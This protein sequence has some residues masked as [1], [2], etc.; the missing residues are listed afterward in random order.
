M[1]AV[2]SVG[3][4]GLFTGGTSRIKESA[5]R[6]LWRKGHVGRF[7]CSARVY[8]QMAGDVIRFPS[9]FNVRRWPSQLFSPAFLRDARLC[10]WLCVHRSASP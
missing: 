6:T 1:N 4:G 10:V 8:E 9:S 3:L 7:C 2:F 5:Q